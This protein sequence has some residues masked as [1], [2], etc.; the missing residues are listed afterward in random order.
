[1]SKTYLKDCK[2]ENPIRIAMQITPH[3]RVVTFRKEAKRVNRYIY[4][5]FIK[6]GVNLMEC[7]VWFKNLAEEYLILDKNLFKMEYNKEERQIKTSSIIDDIG[8]VLRK[9]SRHAQN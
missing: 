6:D 9:R 1:M 5:K 3:E 4:F 8:L 2:N 7:P